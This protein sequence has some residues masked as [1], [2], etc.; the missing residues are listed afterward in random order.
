M[1][2]P[3]AITK[4]APADEFGA[5]IQAATEEIRQRLLREQEN[6][7]ARQIAL[8]SAVISIPRSTCRLHP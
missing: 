5:Q 2:T 7:A 6:W 8:L 3:V 1:N 4:D